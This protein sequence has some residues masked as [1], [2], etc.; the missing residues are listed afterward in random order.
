MEGDIATQVARLP[1]LSR[2]Q[3][4]D[5]WSRLYRKS[6]P[7]GLRREILVPFLAYRIQELAFGGLKLSSLFELR[8]IARTLERSAGSHAPV[9]R[10][11]M[12]TGTRL[13]RKW[14]RETHEVV[15]TESGYEYRGQTYKSLSQVARKITG[16]QWS[17]PAFFG[18]RKT[19]PPGPIL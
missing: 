6:A 5:L 18:L 17:G 19:S 8:R 4:L 16:T 1:I 13:L 10:L 7:E 15:A 11:K 2:R 14:G 12:K 3:L 9:A